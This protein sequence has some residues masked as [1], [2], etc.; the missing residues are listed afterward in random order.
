MK[1]IDLNKLQA[2]DVLICVGKSELSK[3][4]LKAT[5]GTYSHTAQVIDNKNGKTVIFEAQ[6][7]GCDEI[8]FHDWLKKWDYDFIVFR[9][10][11]ENARNLSNWFLQFKGVK[12]D[13]KGFAVG[14]LKSLFRFKRMSEKYR[15]NG[16]FWCSELT[17][18]PYVENPEQYTPQK[19]YEW[20]IANNW[21]EIK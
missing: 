4:I 18:K 12:Y 7:D 6:A 19:V 21:I 15:N 20:L 17:M 1:T 16:Y 11:N 10:P 5:N 13:K 8:D 9:N 3:T 14:L 2:G